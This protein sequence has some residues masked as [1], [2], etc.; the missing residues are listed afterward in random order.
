MK[1]CIMAGEVPNAKHMR[2]RLNPS[3]MY[4]IFAGVPPP[5]AKS[6]STPY[7]TPIQ[8]APALVAAAANAH[9]IQTSNILNI[10]Q[11]NNNKADE[12]T[13]F[14]YYLLLVLQVVITGKNNPFKEIVQS[15]CLSEVKP[16]IKTLR[17]TDCNNLTLS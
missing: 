15:P 17:S 2:G 3:Y 10:I 14:F 5:P 11:R 12:V 6:P 13:G 16:Q 8:P 7:F 9:A 4:L 1:S